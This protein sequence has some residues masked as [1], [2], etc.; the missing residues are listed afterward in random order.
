MSIPSNYI[1]ELLT[2]LSQN[3]I[4][5]IIAQTDAR[6]ILQEIRENPE[7]YPDFDL[8]LTEKATHVAYVLLSCGCSLIENKDSNTSEGFAVLEKAGKILSDAFKY[9]PNELKQEI[10]IF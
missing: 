3:R 1:N 10:I 6:R 7:N 5:N 2:K 4:E 9:N 8:V